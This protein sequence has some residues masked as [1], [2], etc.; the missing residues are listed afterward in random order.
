LYQVY[1]LVASSWADDPWKV[2]E[3][4][5]HRK[6]ARSSSTSNR[7][8]SWAGPVAMVD[9]VK[10]IAQALGGPD[11]T[12]NDVFVSCVT[13]ALARQLEM[14]RRYLMETA[15]DAIS[16]ALLP[17]QKYMNVTVPVHLKGGIVLPGESVGNSLGA[18]VARVPAEGLNSVARLSA[19]HKE[20]NFLKR[21]PA[22]LLSHMM[23]TTLSYAAYVLPPTFTSWMYRKASAGSVAVVTNVR[24]SPKTTHIDGHTVESAY[25]FVP[26]PPGLPVGVVVASYD[27]KMYLSVTAEPWAVP[28]GDEFLRMVLEEYMSLLDKTIAK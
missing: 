5:Y 14:H 16:A 7:V 17:R 11:C 24:M 26:L 15:D 25:G 4:I 8:I 19:V 27:G 23:A 9:Q 3:Q 12:I 20:L 2:L 18:F 6:N 22:A 21:T 13:A 28:D 1:C 10:M